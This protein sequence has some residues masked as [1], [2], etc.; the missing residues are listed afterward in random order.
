MA[1]AYWDLESRL[2]EL[3]FDYTYDKRLCDEIVG[4]DPGGPQ[5]RLLGLPVSFVNRSVHFLENHDEARIAG[6]LSPAEHRAAALLI[7]GLPGMR[8]LHDGQLTGATV[9]T[10]VQL[11]RR[12]TE[13][14]QT[15]IAKMYDALLLTLQRTA[16]GHGR[17]EVL[18][19]REAWVGNPTAQ[20]FV[21]VQWQ[22]RSPTFDL[23]A[24]NLA[25]HRSQ[26]CV[27]LTAPG[28]STGTWT[29]KDLLGNESYERSGADLGGRGAYLDLA[30][31]GAQLFHFEPM[32]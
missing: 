28:L 6:L 27:P 5:R 11:I 9:R 3:G 31:H 1:E 32:G 12:Q 16:V 26:C 29:M 30:A 13:P 2:Q 7:L 24:V 25:P 21:I 14:P 17:G 19:P 22:T 18:V 20:N 10:P 23:V 8:F 4:R 15:D